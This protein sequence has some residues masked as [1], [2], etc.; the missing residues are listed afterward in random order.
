[1][2]TA[3]VKVS[4]V[5]AS[6]VLLSALTL[7]DLLNNHELLPEDVDQDA[8]QEALFNAPDPYDLHKT[9]HLDAVCA[10]DLVDEDG[11]FVLWSSDCWAVSAFVKLD[12]PALQELI[13]PLKMS[14][15]ASEKTVLL[16]NN[17]EEEEFDDSDLAL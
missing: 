11:R 17:I 1:M 3:N 5:E 14:E 15:T 4:P 9:E 10:A 16:S 8:L 6:L 7:M 2:A 13:M 12:S